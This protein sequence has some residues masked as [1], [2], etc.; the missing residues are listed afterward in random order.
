MQYILRD[1]CGIFENSSYNP[2]FK[3]NFAVFHK[4]YGISSEMKCFSSGIRG[5]LDIFG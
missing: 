5:I 1:F 2:I 3:G 4:K